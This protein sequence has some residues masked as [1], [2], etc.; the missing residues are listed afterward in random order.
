[1]KNSIKIE[2]DDVIQG[3]KFQALQNNHNIFFLE[4]YLV[5]D[6]FINNNFLEPFVLITHNSDDK[7]RYGN[8]NEEKEKHEKPAYASLIPKNLIKWFGQNV[9]ANHE[10]VCSIPIGLENSKWFP[11]ERK[12]EKILKIRDCDLEDN[13]LL[14]LSLIHI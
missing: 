7:I 6:F 13:N 9:C 4:T 2:F 11:E 12:I 14:Y 8:D 3:E 10:K 5:N 1:M